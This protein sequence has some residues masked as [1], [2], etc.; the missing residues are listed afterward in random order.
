[1]SNIPKVVQIATAHSR[2]DGEQ[3]GI[4]SLTILTEDGQIWERE[5]GSQWARVA[6]PW[7]LSDALEQTS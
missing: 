6:L 3:Y 4:I 7:E 2:T 5:N 1:M